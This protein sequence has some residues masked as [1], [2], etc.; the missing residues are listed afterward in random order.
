MEIRN[1]EG[2]VMIVTSLAALAARADEFGKRPWTGPSRVALEKAIIRA[3]PLLDHPF[4]LEE[5]AE[6]LRQILRSNC[7]DLLAKM[8]TAKVDSAQFD[9]DCEVIVKA[10]NKLLSFFR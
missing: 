1:V 10:C 8:K 6:G 5:E 4:G 3:E 7:R 9:V 2:K